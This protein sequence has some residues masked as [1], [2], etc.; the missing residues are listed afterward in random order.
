MPGKSRH[1]KG[2]HQQ[3]SRKSKF[4]QRHGTAVPQQ[5]AASG[6]PAPAATTSAPSPAKAPPLTATPAAS[7]YRYVIAEMRR[8]G[9]LSA[10]ILVILIVLSRILP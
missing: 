3:H 1:V 5:P 10:I 6:V 9:I 4:K 2:K 8:I 7:Q